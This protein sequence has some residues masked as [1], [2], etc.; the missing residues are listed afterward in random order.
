MEKFYNL[1]HHNQAFNNQKIQKYLSKFS[2]EDKFCFYGIFWILMEMFHQ[3]NNKISLPVLNTKIAEYQPYTGGH[4]FLTQ[5]KD[6]LNIMIE[7]GLIEKEITDDKE[8]TEYYY[9]PYQRLVLQS[10]ANHQSKLSETNQKL[11]NKVTEQE[12]LIK[13]LNDK[14]DFLKSDKKQIKEKIIKTKF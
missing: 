10:K 14:I 2:E 11:N 12:G 8:Y 5:L 13:R 3:E 9:S 7:V 1:P 4:G 6:A